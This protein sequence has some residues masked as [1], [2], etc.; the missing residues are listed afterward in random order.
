MEN[1]CKELRADPS[2][3]LKARACE[4]QGKRERDLQS[5]WLNYTEW[6]LQ[7]IARCVS[8]FV[9]LRLKCSCLSIQ[10]AKNVTR[11]EPRLILATLLV[12]VGNVPF[13]STPHMSSE[14]HLGVSNRFALDFD[15]LGSA[16]IC[17]F[18]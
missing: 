12:K 7:L 11:K 6:K 13:I 2:N 17:L 1:F 15:F 4:S 5:N 8:F 3:F 10:N 9:Y 16:R 18:I 14:K